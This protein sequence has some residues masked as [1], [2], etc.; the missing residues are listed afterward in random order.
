MDPWSATPVVKHFPK[1][2]C[3]EL[4]I[5]LPD[6]PQKNLVSKHLI[7]NKRNTWKKFF[8]GFSST[9]CLVV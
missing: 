5:G 8:M 3:E 1:D 6:Q 9:F 4:D 2:Q 7:P